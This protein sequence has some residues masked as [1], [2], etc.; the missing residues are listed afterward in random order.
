MAG[1]D[2]IP[3]PA[4]RYRFNLANGLTNR[5]VAQSRHALVL[6]FLL[7][8]H[9]E[10]LAVAD[11]YQPALGSSHGGIQ[12]VPRKHGEMGHRHDDDYGI[13]LRALLLVYG[14]GERHH[15]VLRN[16]ARLEVDRF[17]RIVNREVDPDAPVLPIDRIFDHA[18]VPVVDVAIVVVLLLEHVVALLELEQVVRVLRLLEVA[19]HDRSQEV[20]QGVDA[21][22]GRP[23]DWGDDHQRLLVEVLLLDRRDDVFE[24]RILHLLVRRLV[25]LD[26]GLVCRV[27]PD[28]ACVRRGDDGRALLLAENLRELRHVADLVVDDVAEYPARPHAR[29]LVRVADEHEVLLL[30]CFEQDRGH[31]R[32]HH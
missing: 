16:L 30:A 7:R 3:K 29:E 13:R 22:V 11:E 17:R 32:V 23:L 14:A 21:A 15:Q 2:A 6:E 10:R 27:L 4:I 19:V 8:R 25:E 9:C 18:D 20:V 26:A 1:F 5:V 31:L 24:D 12:E 28:E